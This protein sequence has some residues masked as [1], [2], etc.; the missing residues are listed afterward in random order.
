[1]FVFVAVELEG[2]NGVGVWFAS[3]VTAVDERAV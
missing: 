2:A 3:G 1:M